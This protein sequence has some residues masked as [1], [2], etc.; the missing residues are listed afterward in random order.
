MLVTNEALRK[1][2][3]KQNKSITERAG[4]VAMH[5]PMSGAVRSAPRSVPDSRGGSG[6]ATDS[7]LIGCRSVL[8]APFWFMS[9]IKQP[10]FHQRTW[11]LLG[12]PDL[13]AGSR[14]PQ[15]R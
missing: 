4:E 15:S 12:I 3:P 7:V 14:R 2:P 9:R 11:L 10:E 6:R 5:L 13:S 8:L 1:T